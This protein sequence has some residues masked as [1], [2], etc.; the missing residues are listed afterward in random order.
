MSKLNNLLSTKKV[1]ASGFPAIAG[2]G[3]FSKGTDEV[4]LSTLPASALAGKGI[5]EYYA[6][7]IPRD[8]KFATAQDVIDA[9]LDVQQYK[10]EVLQEPADLLEYANP[11]KTIIVS[12]HPGT[13]DY[14]HDDLDWFM[15]KVFDGNV[16]ADDVKGKHVV[17]TLPPHLVAECDVYTAISIKDFDYTK[18]GDLAGEDF[19]QRV[20]V[21][22]PIK[23]TKVDTKGGK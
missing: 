8:S 22:K 14:I 13:I 12:R 21:N 5:T 20:L 16:T 10:I 6:P 15:S 4:V 11:V 9:D 17:G 2:L 23:L 1:V 7:V 3:E 18:D 19:K